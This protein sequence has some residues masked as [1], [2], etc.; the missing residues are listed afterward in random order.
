MFSRIVC[1][2]H[3]FQVILHLLLRPRHFHSKGLMFKLNLFLKSRL[4]LRLAT[5][6]EKFAEHNHYLRNSVET[7][8]QLNL[9]SQTIN[10][11]VFFYHVSV[12][13][14]ARLWCQSS[15]ATATAADAVPATATQ[16]AL[17]GTQPYLSTIHASTTDTVLQPSCLPATATP[18]IPCFPATPYPDALLQCSTTAVAHC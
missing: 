2:L 5:V 17:P 8:R 15:A 13:T 14:A 6:T 7:C 4:K 3:S 18:A 10:F 16:A 12:S 9:P 11:K 1:I